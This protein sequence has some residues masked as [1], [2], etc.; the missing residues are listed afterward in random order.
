MTVEAGLKSKVEYNGVIE[1][2]ALIKCRKN[3]NDLS[4]EWNLNISPCL[5]N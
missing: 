5:Y 1:E 4:L 2:F 3:V